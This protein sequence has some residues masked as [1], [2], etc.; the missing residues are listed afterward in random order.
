[1][2]GVKCDAMKS[3]EE[4]WQNF[5]NDLNDNI[6]IPRELA[7]LIWKEGWK[8]GRNIVLE[9]EFGD[10]LLKIDYGEAWRDISYE[11][12]MAKE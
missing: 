9:N 11:D 10:D 1:M 6:F 2:L 12:W 5:T 4:F 3:F 7:E 8:S